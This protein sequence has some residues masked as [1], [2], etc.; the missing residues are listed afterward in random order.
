MIGK[1]LSGGNI[2]KHSE[3]RASGGQTMTRCTQPTLSPMPMVVDM[4]GGRGNTMPM[5]TTILGGRGQGI[6]I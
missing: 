6:W 4:T 2:G 1:L 3:V 5:V